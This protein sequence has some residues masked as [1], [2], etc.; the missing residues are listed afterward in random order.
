MISLSF[1]SSSKIIQ[2]F[3]I[4]RRTIQNLEKENQQQCAIDS[5]WRAELFVLWF[6]W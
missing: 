4:Q 6:C 5:H 1:I 3:Y 2:I